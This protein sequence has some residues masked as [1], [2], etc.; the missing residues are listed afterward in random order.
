V[1][2][3]RDQGEHLSLTNGDVRSFRDLV[4]WQ[5]AI[6]LTVEVYRLTERFPKSERFG[7]TS[8]LRRAAASI[9]ANIAEGHARSTRPDYA[10][11]ISIAQGSLAESRTYLHIA[12]RIG[13]ASAN[14]VASIEG[15]ADELSRMLTAL[16]TRLV[17][18]NRAGAASLA[19]DP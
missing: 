14:D 19:P 1:S 9:A 8:Q 15:L 4:V 13:L 3:I 17:R 11:F 6:G 18:P 2:G 16:R 10:R 5:K 12:E 7:L